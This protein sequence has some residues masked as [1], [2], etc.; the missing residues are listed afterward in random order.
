MSP[1]D[2]FNFVRRSHVLSGGLG[3]GGT[4]DNERQTRRGRERKEKHVVVM[5]GG[6]V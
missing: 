6:L 2:A 5:C 1:F 3:G 4:R